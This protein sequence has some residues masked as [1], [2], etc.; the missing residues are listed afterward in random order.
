MSRSIAI[1]R[2]AA[3]Q[4]LTEV[5]RAGPETIGWQ[6]ADGE[7]AI[8]TNA[9]PVFESDEGFAE[10]WEARRLGEPA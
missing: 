3:G 1:I 2:W 10:A 6:R 9:D 7:R 5:W 4:E 8:E